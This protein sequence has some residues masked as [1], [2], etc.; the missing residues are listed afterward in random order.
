MMDSDNAAGKSLVKAPAIAI[1]ISNG[2]GMFIALLTLVL[3]LF[4]VVMGTASG[5]DQ[6]MGL[7]AQGAIGVVQSVLGLAIGAAIIVGILKMM[8]LQSYGFAMTANVLAMIPCLSPCC[9]F[10]LPFGIWGIV[11][12][13]KPEVK[14]A[15][16]R[17]EAEMT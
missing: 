7:V 14:E 5:V 12:L 15:F 1:L 13:C 9:L 8:K 4:G 10:G 3:N 6:G 11:I 2:I 17:V 16:A